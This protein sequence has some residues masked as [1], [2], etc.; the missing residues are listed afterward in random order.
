[1]NELRPMHDGADL[2]PWAS[3]E[4]GPLLLSLGA[5]SGTWLLL[6]AFPREAKR[7]HWAWTKPRNLSTRN[8]SETPRTLGVVL[9]HVVGALGAAAGLETL[10]AGGLAVPLV[11]AIPLWLAAAS[12]L[13]W[14]GSRLAFGAGD[15]SSTLV[16]LHRHN[17]AWMGMALACWATV[18]SLNPYVKGSEAAL[19]GTLVVFAAASFHSASRASQLIPGGNAQRVV[20][21]LYLCTLEW[22]WALF[23]TLWS[24]RVA[25]EGGH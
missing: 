18:A 21:I 22:G 11:W 1:M 15:L 14:L 24:M 16:E 4:M 10:R 19:W 5:L 20:G 12:G 8:A 3:P 7:L 6:A 13:K 2:T 17:Q 23:W 9:N 25:L